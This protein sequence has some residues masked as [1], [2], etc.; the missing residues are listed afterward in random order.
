VISPEFVLPVTMQ[1]TWL[2]V[3]SA[4]WSQAIRTTGPP[5]AGHVAPLLQTRVRA[6]VLIL[7]EAQQTL[8]PLQV[9]LPQRTLGP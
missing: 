6:F 3:Q 9:W 4:F 5:A 1:H 7:S 8:L 2:P